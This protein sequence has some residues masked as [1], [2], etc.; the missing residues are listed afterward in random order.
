[1]RQFFA[2]ACT[3]VRVQSAR[4]KRNAKPRSGAL[5]N[6]PIDGSLANLFRASGGSEWFNPDGCITDKF[7]MGGS[8]PARPE[9]ELEL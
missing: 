6:V 8:K 2:K 1:M 7:E 5:Y 9:L 4:W 3:G